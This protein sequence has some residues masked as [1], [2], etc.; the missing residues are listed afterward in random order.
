MQYG[1][2]VKAMAVYLN[3]QQLIPEDRLSNVFGDL[4]DLLIRE[5]APPNSASVLSYAS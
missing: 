5:V 2:R 3:H 4:F 1:E